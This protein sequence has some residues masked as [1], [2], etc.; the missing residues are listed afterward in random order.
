MLYDDG[1]IS[2]EQE[3]PNKDRVR[4]DEEGLGNSQLY[5][6]TRRIMALNK[7]QQILSGLCHTFAAFVYTV[8]NNTNKASR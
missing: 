5:H 1:F 2:V 8:E 7:L 3:I 4:K 6:N